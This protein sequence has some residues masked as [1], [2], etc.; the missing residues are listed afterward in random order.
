[1]HGGRLDAQSGGPGLGSTFLLRLPRAEATAETRKAQDDAGAFRVLVVDD[2]RDSA[3]SATAII[4]LLGHEAESAYDGAGALAV[5]RRFPADMVLLDLSM[6]VMDGFQTLAQL[7]R[8]PGFEQAF[9]VAMTGY[10]G[11]DDKRRTSDAG[12][13]AH[14]TKPVELTALNRLLNEARQRA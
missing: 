5:A 3:D 13:N 4:R 10:G 7:R 2:N 1:M 9:V 6:P 8:V 11:T 14:L 12:F